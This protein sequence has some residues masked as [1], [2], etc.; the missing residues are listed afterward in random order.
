MIPTYKDFTH[1]PS[2]LSVTDAES[3]YQEL[4]DLTTAMNDRKLNDLVTNL[5]QKAVTYTEV[6][7]QWL[8]LSSIEKM[9]IDRHRT[10]L[11]NDFIAA[12]NIVQRYMKQKDV[13][14]DWYE[15]LVPTG[16]VDRKRVG[17]FACYISY[18]YAV[19]AR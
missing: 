12:V 5:I 13:P 15:R 10:D 8:L 4:V 18:V 14:T 17:D 6:R 9:Q 11:H 2:H 3:I 7:A 16:I 1:Q 19:N